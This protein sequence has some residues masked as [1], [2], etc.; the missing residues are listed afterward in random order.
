[1]DDARQLLPPA[2]DRLRQILS[3]G[4]PPQRPPT[5]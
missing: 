5:P 4:A 3:T 2:Y 1:V